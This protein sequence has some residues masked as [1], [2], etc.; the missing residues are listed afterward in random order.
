MIVGMV[1]LVV[2]VVGTIFAAG[3][4]VKIGQLESTLGTDIFDDESSVNDKTLLQVVKDLIG[5]IRDLDNLTINK[6]KTDYGMK[7]P[8]EISG[9][10]ISVVFDLPVTEVP[11]HLGDI[12]N[13][14][15]LRDVGELIGTD[16]EQEYPDLHI[17]QDNLDEHVN[18]ALD[19][20]L[21][22]IDDENMTVYTIGRDFGLSLGENNLIETLKHTPLNSFADVMDNLPIGIVADADSDLFVT[23]GGTAIYVKTDVY[24]P[25]SADELSSSVIADGAETYIAGADENGVVYRELRFVNAGTEDAPSYIP[26]NSCYSS[27]FDAATN[28]KTF[29]RH[30]EYVPYNASAGYDGSTVFAVR[31]LLN[32]V[33]SDGEGGLMLAD[34]GMKE[35]DLVFTDEAMTSSLSAYILSTPDAVKDGKFDFASIPLYIPTTNE[36]GETVAA[37]DNTFGFLAEEISEDELLDDKGEGYIR[38]HVGTA[39]PSMQ[40][41][42]GET[43][44]SVSGATD[45]ITK[46]KLSQVLDID[47]TS[48]KVLQALADTPI[49]KMSEALNE[50][51]LQEATDIVLSGYTEDDNGAYVLVSTENGSS[52]YTLYDP[53]VEAHKGLTRYARTSVEGESSP[54]L[55]RL[56]NV[57]IP[58]ISA[59]F[60]EM[61]LGDALA[62]D[63]DIF[64]VAEAPDIGK[65]YFIFENG[66]PSRIV[67]DESYEE[68][69]VY[70]RVYE[71][72]SNSVLKQL[73]YVPIDDVPE[74]MDEIIDNTLLSDII[75]VVSNTSVEESASGDSYVFEHDAAYTEQNDDG[76]MSYYTFVYDNNGSFFLSPVTYLPA[77]DFQLKDG[78]TKA[79]VYMQSNDPDINSAAEFIEK[80]RDNIYFY[81]DGEYK[82]NPALVAYYAVN[83]KLE[84][85]KESYRRTESSTAGEDAEIATVYKNVNGLTDGSGLYVMSHSVS[86]G[87]S[88]EDV[89]RAAFGRY[90]PYDPNDITH[91]GE[92]LFFK[93][94]NGYYPASPEQADDRDVRKYS[95]SFDDGTFSENDKGEYV[96]LEERNE[97]ETNSGYYYVS[98]SDVVNDGTTEYKFDASKAKY[99]K[100]ECDYIY[101]KDDE[102]DY[103]S[104]NGE[105]VPKAEAPEENDGTFRRVIGYLGNRAALDGGEN[106]GFYALTA[107]QVSVLTEKSPV[108][109]IS[110]LEKG[111][112]VG[113][114]NEEIGNLTLEDL[115][116]IEP[117]SLFDNQALRTAKIDEVSEAASD[118]FNNMTIGELLRYAGI[119]ASPEVAYILQDVMLADFFDALEY[120][121]TTATI[122]VNMERLFGISTP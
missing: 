65:T 105:F 118:L 89:V 15:T 81:S 57:T 34:G 41:I 79:F 64:E 108:I 98:L 10:D 24:E 111:I 121:T 95:F 63:A 88:G 99:S 28:D 19:N 32:S 116:E 31:T 18:V 22:S 49:N 106:S 122:V 102:G 100:R 17:L 85:L 86:A 8:N 115:M 90:V 14:M 69:T 109:M 84:G 48:A 33:V 92:K 103:A 29:Y 97:S 60:S 43:L 51:T 66:Y 46:L 42:A 73:L 110:L 120:D 71:G 107:T 91:W 74:K 56:A 45:E 13:N 3:S 117:G 77:K 26:D 55:Q 20:I 104:V 37:D 40:V 52:F 114:L 2:A 87:S 7:I 112:T 76:E 27:S 83:D 12:V 58:N 72:T 16:F 4:L 23:T 36:A 21:S 82:P 94:K 39:D 119:S 53:S 67:Y 47:E 38:I 54:A 113:S 25:V 61:I 50:L 30:I 78:E 9:I 93:Y 75:D 101:I 1:L 59:A 80:Y 11:D 5:D 35:L 68:T 96:L 6:L 62:A 44:K 70:D